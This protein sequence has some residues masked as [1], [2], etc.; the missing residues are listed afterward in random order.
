M[1]FSV[2]AAFVLMISLSSCVVVRESFFIPVST[3][4][5]KIVSSSPC[6]SYKN[7]IKYQFD[8]VYVYIDIHRIKNI[9]SI[10]IVFE[11]PIGNVVSIQSPMLMVNGVSE[12]WPAPK[13]YD[14][15]KAIHYN[16]NE[17]VGNG[18]RKFRMIVDMNDDLPR[19]FNYVLKFN[20]NSNF[21]KINEF[22]IMINGK[23]FV[24][25]ESYFEYKP[26]TYTS[27]INC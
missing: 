3:V 5:G 18:N 26:V 12:K 13:V 10:Y 16:N 19:R 1:K 22:S 27:S 25:P 21:Y 7:K 8:D 14:F 11:I 4:S 6:G 20:A 24:I 15:L 9:D 23:N 17:L 2:I